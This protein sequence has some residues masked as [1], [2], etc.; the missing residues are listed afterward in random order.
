MYFLKGRLPWQ[1]LNVKVKEMRY[2]KILEK[3]KE[4]TSEALCKGFPNEFKEYVEYTR[5]L[6]YEEEPNYDRLRCLFLNLV[7]DKMGENFDFIYDWTTSSDLKKR[8][9]ENYNDIVSS[10][11]YISEKKS[12]IKDID[13]L[14]SI[15]KKKGESNI[16]NLTVY[17]TVHSN[18]NIS[19]NNNII[20]D[21]H[22]LD[23]KVESK[24]CLM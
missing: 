24:C 7:C 3:K 12:K 17:K 8:K 16:N 11:Y 1:G 22:N 21:N 9:E 15:K 14:Y 6:G 4:T 10:T 13:S 18:D 20:D 23:E 5:N 19:K 2:Q